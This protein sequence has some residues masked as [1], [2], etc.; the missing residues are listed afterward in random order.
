MTGGKDDH[1][2]YS[3]VY[4]R[5]I[6]IRCASAV[7]RATLKTYKQLA[8]ASFETFFDALPDNHKAHMA[9]VTAE[10][11]GNYR[12]RHY[13]QAI[14]AITSFDMSGK[15]TSDFD[16]EVGRFFSKIYTR[17]LTERQ[18]IFTLHRASHALNVHVWERL[19]LPLTARTGEAVFVAAIIPREFKAEF[20]QAVLTSSPD[21]IFA[22]RSLRDRNGHIADGIIVAA[23]DRFALPTG[24]TVEQL[25]GCRLMEI[26]PGHSGSELWRRYVQVI[27]TRQP[28]LFEAEYYQDGLN[29]YYRI[30]AVPLGDGLNVCFTDI[31]TLK[32]AIA[33][34]EAALRNAETAREELRRQSITDHLTG[35]LN[36]SGFDTHLGRL[37]DHTPFVVVAIDLDRFK[38]VNDLYGH[39]A[40]DA[41][42]KGLAKIL[43]TETR[44]DHDI[45]GRIGGE[46]F[47]IALPNAT[48]ADAAGLAERIRIRL[49][50]TAFHKGT[51]VFF[52]TASFGVW[53][54]SKG[55]ALQT[56]LRGA[57][58]A[59]YRAKRAGRNV[60]VCAEPHSA[61]K[62]SLPVAQK[63]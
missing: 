20:L 54:A 59:L 22:L 28:E 55:E 17:A 21:A 8:D 52:V 46:E 39:A 56:V 53:Q 44:A 6:E 63:R 35:V 5:E 23:N 14:V 49:A 36:R 19:V 61:V 2:M 32:T 60:V 31:T 41:V 47:M 9:V 51:D 37:H 13:G 15:C 34:A 40:G 45:L 7:I 58:D 18:P 11:D 29:G 4:T 1:E 62:G 10:P 30:S 42:L 3:E 48:L 12:Y 57:D 38:A 33:S 25:E 26:M 24:R 16:S 27:E 43:S 50:C